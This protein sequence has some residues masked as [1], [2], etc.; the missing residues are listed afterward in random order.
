MIVI[1]N[2]VIIKMS[3]KHVKLSKKIINK[4]TDDPK[5]FAKNSNIDELVIFLKYCSDKYYNTSEEV[6][7]DDVF[8]IHVC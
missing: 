4:V 6:V 2:I 8:D 3:S 1:F 5:A 7:S